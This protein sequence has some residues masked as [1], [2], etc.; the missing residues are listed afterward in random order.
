MRKQLLLTSFLVGAT[1][2]LGG[3]E[4]LRAQEVVKARLTAPPEVPPPI[5]RT[6]PAR[7]LVELT[8]E[9]HR[10]QLEHREHAGPRGRLGQRRE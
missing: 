6:R 5:D 4:T 8:S 7:V 2:L 3:A 10:A 9:E 1:L